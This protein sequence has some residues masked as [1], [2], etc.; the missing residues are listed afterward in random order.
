M[1]I[2]VIVESPAKAKKIQSYLGSNY[3]VKA[4]VGHVR[5]LAKTGENNLG[6]DIANNFMPKY[7]I[8]EGKSKVVNDLK[9]QYKKCSDVILAADQDR[10][11]EAIAWHVAQLLGIKEPK[12]M[13][14]HEITKKALQNAV[15]NLRTID[16]NLVNAQQARAVLDKLVGYEISP[17]LWKH[18]QY[19]LSAGRVQSSALKLVNERETLIENFE[20]KTY[21]KTDGIF[22]DGLIGTLNKNFD[23]KNVCKDFLEKCKTAKFTIGNI[24]KKK[25]KRYPSAPFITST[26]QQEAGRK[27]EQ[28]SK[29]I[30]ANAQTLYENGFITYHRTDSVTLSDDI[31]SDIKKYV[32]ANYGENYVNIRKYKNKSKNAQE[33]HEA[34]RPT[35]IYRVNIDDVDGM[36]TQ[37]KKLYEIIWKRT[38]ASQMAPCE[39][40]MWSLKID[41]SNTVEYFVA[42]AEKIIFPGF[43]VVYDYEETDDDND[44]KE[45]DTKTNKNLK[46]IEKL[47]I[48]A[49]LNMK[50]IT[51]T[52]K[53]T[54]P[55]PRFSEPNLVKKMEELGIGRPSTFASIITTIQERKY[56]IKETRKGKKVPYEIMFLKGN[57]INEKKG[58][59]T[60]EAE[61]NKLFITDIGKIVSKFLE[62]Q[63]SNIVDYNFTSNIENELDIVANGKKKWNDVVKVVY[64]EFHPNVAKLLE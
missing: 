23:A 61:K 45:N 62:E 32:S 9:E 20:S 4:S 37:H 28:G 50:E 53:F 29:A 54:K 34:I 36:T 11:G 41:L 25:V 51:S 7:V 33:A 55:T 14:F 57:I 24:E 22:D 10:E 42:K 6:I 44:D 43:K 56:V 21:W 59:T 58:E 38:M 13:V 18:V 63:F 47:Q 19:G 39:V 31:V 27:L 26:L 2:L 15:N 12:R 1:P 46:I 17:V 16:Y 35:D 30:M 8:A 64:D 48:G 40:E 52:E 49:L 3:I 60:M 5:Q